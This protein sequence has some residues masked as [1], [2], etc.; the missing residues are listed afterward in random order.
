MARK[1]GDR[2]AMGLTLAPPPHRA[3]RAYM[4][5]H[6]RVPV[7]VMR[8][9][10]YFRDGLMSVSL[11]CGGK[12]NAIVAPLLARWRRSPIPRP[13]TLLDA[14]RAWRALPEFGRLDLTITTGKRAL[15]VQELRVSASDFRARDW[16]V[17]EPGLSVLGV[18]LEVAAH[19]C[20][21]DILSLATVSLHALARRYQRGF[22]ITDAAIMHDLHMLAKA[23]AELGSA[24]AAT[25]FEV[26]VPGG[27]RWVGNLIDVTNTNGGNSVDCVAAART[28]KD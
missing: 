8:Q 9:A 11:D 22:A 24:D 28:Y 26:V 15:C 19:R 12:M 1:L 13:E 23:H 5:T 2:S 21:F 10:R 6:T 25:E 18:V 16:T 7:E 27:G 17:D 14:A 4:Q 3:A 20:V